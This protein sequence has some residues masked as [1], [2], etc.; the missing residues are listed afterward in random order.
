[1][2]VV[3]PVEKF[4]EIAEKCV[5]CGYFQPET[6]SKAAQSSQ[7]VLS[8]ME[9]PNPH[10]ETFA[11]LQK[12]MDFAKITPEY[13]DFDS[14][15]ETD[16]VLNKSID[17]FEQTLVAVN[18]KI[19]EVDDKIADNRFLISQL[20][21]MQDIHVPVETVFSCKYVFLRFGHLPRASYDKIV[22]HGLPDTVLMTPTTIDKNTVWCFWACPI[23]I[24]TKT[25]AFFSALFFERFR[26]S[27]KA[28]GIPAEQ[29][30]SLEKELVELQQQHDAL[31]A[32]Y[33]KIVNDNREHLLIAY[34]KHQYL[35]KAYELRKYAG[36]DSFLFYLY[37]WVP[38]KERHAFIDDLCQTEDITVISRDPSEE[39]SLKPPTK[40]KNPWGINF[41]EQFVSMYGVPCYN[42]LD[43]TPLVALTYTLFFGI[44]FGDVGQ[45]IVLALAGLFAY[46]K[47]KMPLGK[48]MTVIGISSTAFGFFY[49]SVFGNEE[50]IK[51]FNFHVLEG[52]NTL[53]TLLFA[54]GV[55]ILL[56]VGAMLLN[57]INGIKQKNPQ[58]I[59]FDVNG[60]AG[61]VLFAGNITALLLM[62]V[63]K[64][65]LYSPLFSV[66]CIVLPLIC[67]FLREPLGKLCAGDKKWMPE[68]FG[69]YCM[70][71]IFELIEVFLSFLSNTISYV[72]I[73]AF[74]VS[75][76][77][78]MLVV[79]SMSE[80][81]TGV[82]HVL[83][84]VF[85]NILV[86]GLE[87]LIV[88]IQGLRLQFYEFFSRFYTGEG[89]VY[90]PI[91][92]Q[93]ENK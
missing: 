51:G 60:L 61:L 82:A 17:E 68:K 65:N 75:H 30:A 34:S 57:I 91:T 24:A 6:R 28:H 88:G 69:E 83:I 27:E 76:A 81:A 29:I 92:I 90:E 14:F 22:Q 62:F 7:T 39:P 2:A 15:D 77:G 5:R 63:K 13:R 87:G 3:G 10:A 47:L 85:G 40:L 80:M 55:G 84:L 21:P 31:Y 18:T 53:F 73:G 46:F 89:T 32:E 49:G 52:N 36:E 59:F 42:E 74:A 45:G 20:E 8:P 23:D 43:P 37:G 58:K 41:F 35:N 25:N 66:V 54:A 50:W 72:R 4:D 16:E 12:A 71:N 44:M 70:E 9:E 67:I 64:I 79:M 93:F 26:L 86:I 1:M 33:E 48:I 38:K 19:K 56:I 78:M 11:S